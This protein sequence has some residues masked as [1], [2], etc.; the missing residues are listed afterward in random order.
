MKRDR[1]AAGFTL[2]ELLV[3]IA[4]ILIV[5][6]TSIYLV[7]GFFKGSAVKEAGRV[8][9]AAFARGRQQASTTRLV[10][11]LVF[12]F[13]A[14]VMRLHVD[15]NR[16][17]VFTSADGTAAESMPLPPNV[18]FDRVAG[19]TSGGPYAA[20]QPDGSVTMHTST[21]G[22]FPDVSWSGTGYREGGNDPPTSSD[23]TVRLGPDSANA[24]DKVYIDVVPV[25]G[26]IRKMEYYHRTGASALP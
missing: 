26:M 1:A 19:Q 12:D 7:G 22:V 15:Q 13:G 24:P 9:A 16:D 21:G 25:T 11:F 18:Y 17:R 8:V 3:V 20:F 10:H 14:S 4:I 23:I 6:S 2:I 5:V